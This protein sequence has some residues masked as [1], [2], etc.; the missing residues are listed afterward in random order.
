MLVLALTR[1]AIA[2]SQTAKNSDRPKLPYNMMGLGHDELDAYDSKGEP[3]AAAAAALVAMD[4]T[5]WELIR[6]HYP[7]LGID[8]EGAKKAVN[9]Q[10]PS[11]SRFYAN[12][13]NEDATFSPVPLLSAIASLPPAQLSG[14]LLALHDEAAQAVVVDDYSQWQLAKLRQEVDSM[15]TAAKT[16]QGVKYRTPKARLSFAQAVHLYAMTLALLRM[17]NKW[18]DKADAPPPDMVDFTNRLRHQ[19]PRAVA[20]SQ[21]VGFFLYRP[22]IVSHALSKDDSEERAD[23]VLLSRN[24]NTFHLDQFPVYLT[25]NQKEWSPAWIEPRDETVD[26]TLL[27]RKFEHDWTRLDGPWLWYTPDQFNGR[28]VYRATISFRADDIV[29]TGER[30][31]ESRGSVKRAERPRDYDPLQMTPFLAG[32]DAVAQASSPLSV[33]PPELEDQLTYWRAPRYF[34][35][36]FRAWCA[37]GL[38]DSGRT[39]DGRTWITVL[40]DEPRITG[41]D[42]APPAIS[43]SSPQAQSATQR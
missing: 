39:P 31:I 13:A 37:Y 21:T 42:P 2:G 24:G 36:H 41:A 3:V 18:A 12:Y 5:G 32:K 17:E 30:E 8:S 6:K 43:A 35:N 19:L 27:A 14:H 4:R 7:A 25:A 40:P 15:T 33:Q 23:V 26:T 1:P 10:D 34:S 38:W 29:I 20:D 11:D 16:V 22:G 9:P 28:V